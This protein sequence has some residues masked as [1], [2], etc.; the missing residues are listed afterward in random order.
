M[1][2]VNY[3][4]KTEIRD[5]FNTGNLDPSAQNAI[6]HQLVKDGLYTTPDNGNAVWVE[7]DTFQGVLQPPLFGSD[8]SPAVSPIIQ[9]LEVAGK[10]VTVQT[11]DTLKVIVDDGSNPHNTLNVIGG[12]SPEFI[13]LG[14]S[15]TTVNLQDSG[16]DTVRAGSGDD[17]ITGNSGDDRLVGGSGA[18]SL[19]GGS[20]NDTLIAGTGHGQL[21]VGGSGSDHIRDL[22]SLGTDTLVAG[23]GSD[24]ITGVQGDAFLTNGSAGG[25]DLYRI[26]DGPG[27]ST[28]N[29]GSG[30]DTVNFITSAGND[31]V[32]N[33]GGADTVNFKASAM[34][35]FNT[36]V[37][38]IVS[39]TGANT[40]DYLIQFKDGQSV[41][42]IGHSVSAS[43][44]A[45]TVEFKDV[46]I[47]LKGGS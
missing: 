17:S 41:D 30:Q 33:G 46:N 11:D 25:N 3:L 18:D 20:G 27:N 23:S 1:A 8:G 26:H 14:N 36:D 31:T 2:D 45:F 6:I 21:L 10:D 16:N 13:V 4:T 29:L 39:G 43:Q 40:G 9:V 42:L 35:N 38:G 24:T 7:S 28:I 12:N 32:T 15:N 37:T 44:T 19:F 5:A 22:N 34:D 47:T